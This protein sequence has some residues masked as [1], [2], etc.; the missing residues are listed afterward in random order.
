MPIYLEGLAIQFFR[1][2]GPEMQKLGPFRE[3]NFFV[4]A[5]NSGKSTVL[6]FIHRYLPQAEKRPHNLEFLDEYRGATAGT[7][8]AAIG[9]SIKRFVENA[10]E[11]IGAN[12]KQ[13]ER[14]VQKI[15]TALSDERFV[16]IKFSSEG[17]NFEYSKQFTPTSFGGVL[18]YD[19][20]EELWGALTNMRGGDMR[21]WVPETLSRLLFNQSPRFPTVRFI[22]TNRQIGGKSEHF[23][24]FSG[25]GLI[26]RL[27]ELQSPDHDKRHELSLFQKVNWFL[28]NVTGRNTAKIEIPHN[29][30]HILVHM[31][32]KVLP[33]AN[34]GTGIHE[35]IMIAAFCTISENEIVCIEEPE[36]YLHPLL[37]RKLIS[38]LQAN[39]SN[40]ILYSD[41]LS[42]FYRH[43]KCSDLSRYQRWYANNNQGEY[44]S[45][46]AVRDLL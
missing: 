45:P 6:D 41:A 43:T 12:S 31:D 35:V 28:R 10:L 24:D 26:D 23:E 2:I 34:L 5:N 22:P 30:E 40:S 46:R 4:G 38:Y 21:T 27:A 1:G 18:K 13:F 32:D 39:T 3:F 44:S 8:S 17:K 11:G 9:I 20:W 15:T 37:Q 25:R 16:W 42:D 7:L 36:S 29:R 14:D 19:A 33:L